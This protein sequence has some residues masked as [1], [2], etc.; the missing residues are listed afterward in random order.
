[1]RHLSRYTMLW[2]AGMLAIGLACSVDLGGIEGE[3]DAEQTLQAIYIQQTVDGLAQPTVEDLVK[4]V[5]P[6]PTSTIQV[7]HTTFPGEPGWV[8]QWWIDTGSASTAGQKR[9]S[10]GDIFN[11]NMLERPFTANEMAY[12]PDVDLKRVEISKDET[13]YYF[14]LHL[15]GVNPDTNMLSAVY[16][17]EIDIDRDGRGDLLLWAPGDG[18]TAWNI[19]DVAVYRDGNKDVGGTR[20]MLSDAPGYSGDSY[21]TVLFSPDR[22]DDPDMAWKRVAPADAGIMQ[23]AIKKSLLGNASVFMWS[24]WA[25]D[26]IKNPVMFDPNDFLTQS[27]AGSPISGAGDYPLKALYLVDN[28]CRL[29][30]G[31]EPTGREPNVCLTSR[32]TPEP[33]EEEEPDVVEWHEPCHCADF[34]NYTFIRDAACCTYCGYEWNAANV[35]FPCD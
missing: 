1:M 12:R 27:E 34:P 5:V 17:V 29:P 4:T 23:L 25:D 6:A 10:G 11:Q 14:I 13:F 31:F 3:T 21:E 7:V 9:A 30:Y 8:S 20:P 32:P 19:A 22:L 2:I 16:G 28:T 33:E 24:A 35:E 18:N 26:G 15:E